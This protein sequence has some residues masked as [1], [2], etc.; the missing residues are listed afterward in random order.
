LTIKSGWNS[1]YVRYIN[2]RYICVREATDSQRAIFA[3]VLGRFAPSEVS[4]VDGKPFTR[5][6]TDQ[7]FEGYCYY[8][9]PFPELKDVTEFLEILRSNPSL[10]KCFEEASMPFKPQSKI[11]VNEVL[12]YL[13]IKKKPM[14]YNPSADCLCTANDNE[15]PY[16]LTLAFYFKDELIW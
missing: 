8:S 1:T 12:K 7:L 14:C 10:L 9:Y 5:N 2:S 11:W 6:D 3:K 4:I 13:F 16:R 15:A